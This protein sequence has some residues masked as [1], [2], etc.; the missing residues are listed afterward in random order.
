MAGEDVASVGHCLMKNREVICGDLSLPLA[1][2]E[3]IFREHSGATFLRTVT[4][5]EFVIL[6]D[7]LRPAETVFLF[8][9]GHVAQPTA[10]LAALVGF[11]VRVV[12]DRAAFANA[13]RFPEAQEIRAVT[14]FDG[15]LKELD[16]DRSTFI[17][18]V[19]RGHLHDQ[20][21]LEQ[22][23]RSKAVYIGMIGSRNKRDHIFK[24]LLRQG[25]T[26]ADLNRVHCPIGLNI[27]AETPEEIALSIV[28]E[29]V[30]FR[31]KGRGA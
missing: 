24:A 11:S 29:M 10:R 3:K 17:V 5:G 26:E 28:A 8:G 6:I 4:I 20:T 1:T 7:P 19:T 13:E 23:L 12:D 21:V 31:A 15:A 18:I 22:A 2:F 30:R 25:F 27:G 9:A 14:S 16:I